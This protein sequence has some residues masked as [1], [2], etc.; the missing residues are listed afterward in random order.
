[1]IADDPQLR[2]VHEKPLRQ[3][4]AGWGKAI[5]SEEIAALLGS[6]VTA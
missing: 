6:A 2:G 3:F 1:L 4:I 5:G